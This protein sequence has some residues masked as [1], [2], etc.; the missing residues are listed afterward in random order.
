MHGLEFDAVS[1]KSL[2]TPSIIQYQRPSRWQRNYSLTDLRSM[3]ARVSNSSISS[4]NYA[5]ST[6]SGSSGVPG[7]GY[8]S[9][10]VVKWVGTQIL[11]MFVPLVI[12]RRRR[13]INGLIKQIDV[14][15]QGDLLDWILKKERK[16]NRAAEDLLELTM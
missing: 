11:D 7:I 6:L 12:F 1:V 13:V 10:K 2:R 9:G 15:P 16:I 4:H 5:L 8:L 3:R 14:M